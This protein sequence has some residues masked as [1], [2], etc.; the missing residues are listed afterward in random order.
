VNPSA[1]NVISLCHDL[2]SLA[3]QLGYVA[4]TVSLPSRLIGGLDK[5]NASGEAL[6]ISEYGKNRRQRDGVALAL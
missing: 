3:R 6:Y 5:G 1:R 2:G 4:E